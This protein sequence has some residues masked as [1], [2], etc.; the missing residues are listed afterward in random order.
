MP[1]KNSVDT[2]S[3]QNETEEVT[4]LQ[5]VF[6][7]HDGM[8]NWNFKASE[9]GDNILHVCFISNR[10]VLVRSASQETAAYWA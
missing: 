4:V 8:E 6:Y 5:M 10:T 1:E 3:F 2:P 7:C 9:N